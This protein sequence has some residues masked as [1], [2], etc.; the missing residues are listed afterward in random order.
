MEKSCPV[1]ADGWRGDAQPFKG[2]CVCRD[3]L[4][5]PMALLPPHVGSAL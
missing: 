3:G 5:P 2:D 4:S 1:L